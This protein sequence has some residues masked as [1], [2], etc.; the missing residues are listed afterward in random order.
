MMHLSRLA[1]D[2]QI[3]DDVFVDLVVVI[4]IVR[5]RLVEP[6]RFTRVGPSGKNSGRPFVVARPELRIPD[7]GISRAVKDQVRF[8]IVRHPA[9]RRAAA[10]LPLV[11]RPSADAEVLSFF[12]IVK[13]FEVRPDQHVRVGAGAVCLPRELSGICVDRGKPAANAEFAAAIADDDLVL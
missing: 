12:R 7:A 4:K 6:D 1:A 9:P 10:N 3:D 5:V 8:R 11:G 2:R 13:R